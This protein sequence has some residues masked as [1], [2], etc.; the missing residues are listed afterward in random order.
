MPAGLSSRPN[1]AAWEHWDK[2][3]I[4]R[5]GARSAG[6]LAPK[7]VSRLMFPIARAHVA[8]EA[9]LV[10]GGAA[11]AGPRSGRYR[12]SAGGRVAVLV[13]GGGDRRAL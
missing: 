8:P 7:R 1:S 5:T 10:T 11:L 9:V 6:S 2:P 13:C 3:E 4:G 12:P